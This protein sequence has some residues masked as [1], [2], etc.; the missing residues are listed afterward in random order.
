MEIVWSEF[1]VGEHN[2]RVKKLGPL[3]QLHVFRRVTPLLVPIHAA[4]KGKRVA[5]LDN[6]SAM[7]MDMA[8]EATSELSSLSDEHLDYVMLKC[9]GTV[10]IKAPT[11]EFL[12]MTVRGTLMYQQ[13][14]LPELLQIVWVV[15]LEN[16]SPFFS[17]L[18]AGLSKGEDREPEQS[19][20]NE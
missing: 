9:L 5:G 11:G 12:P 8:M 14:T 16:F 2:Y 7:L 4:I 6:G 13:L 15:L 20:S 10:E 19:V 18:L 3:E 17:G 1:S